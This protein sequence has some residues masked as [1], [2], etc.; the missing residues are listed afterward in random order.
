MSS[1]ARRGTLRHRAAALAAQRVS[2]TMRLKLLVLGDA[3]V[4]KSA[5]LRRYNADTSAADGRSGSDSDSGTAQAQLQSGAFDP[6][7]PA[8]VGV[9][10]VPAAVVGMRDADGHGGRP[11][12]VQVSFF[13]ASGAAAY[14]KVRGEFYSDLHGCLFAF[15]LTNRAS[16]EHV[17]A[18]WGE[19]VAA[20]TAAAAAGG[21]AAALDP[22]SL[23]AVVVGCKADM[24]AARAVP[25][26]DVKQW[27]RSRGATYFECSAKTGAGVVRAVDYLIQHAQAEVRTMGAPPPAAAAQPPPQ[28][29]Q[30]QQQQRPPSASPPPSSSPPPGGGSGPVNIN[31]LSV[32]ELRR[33]C[34]K[35]GLSTDDCLEKSDL[36]A[37]LRSSL[38]A[39]R[40][41]AASQVA[42]SRSRD[43]RLRD[44]VL[45]DV[46]RWARG[47]DVRA[48]LN[49]IHG[50]TEG[51][52]AYLEK[53]ASLAPV[54]LAYKKALLK[55]H[56]D[57]ADPKDPQA[58][59]RATEMFKTV[60]AAFES[61]KKVNEQRISS[62]GADG[63]G[64]GHA[65]G[66]QQ[67]AASPSASPTP[68]SN[69]T[70]RTRPARR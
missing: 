16:W 53:H 17:D 66:Q 37:R 20:R 34:A 50:W 27:C 38:A 8:T 26:R 18:W 4:G 10:F 42:E 62:A 67:P 58:H 14:A 6:S 68:S 11:A 23:H 56:P 7:L 36:L 5:L 15:D 25:E 59:L 44:A 65:H 19:V 2:G 12:R 51:S 1:L 60:N 9:D 39:S 48:M 32:S 24:E 57:K 47:K 28:Q 61:F 46:A 45:A 22:S 41:S 33:E 35:R 13:D 30:S 63:H 31:E 69:P 55:I 54:Q 52:A 29:Q 49:D 21:A 64:H 43:E 70:P 3:G 40:A